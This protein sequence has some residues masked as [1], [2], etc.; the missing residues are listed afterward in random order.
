MCLVKAAKVFPRAK[1][2]K[3]STGTAVIVTVFPSP[4]SFRLDWL[5]PKRFH[6]KSLTYFIYTFGVV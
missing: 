1:F 2:Y 5:S 4:V 3:L 6:P